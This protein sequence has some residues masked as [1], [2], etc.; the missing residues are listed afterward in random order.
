MSTKAAQTT[1]A[2]AGLF[3]RV[4]ELVELG[5]L[6]AETPQ[7]KRLLRRIEGALAVVQLA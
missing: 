4:L 3:E 1:D 6:S 7:A 2:V 5:E